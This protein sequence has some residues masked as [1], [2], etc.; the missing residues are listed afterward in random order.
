MKLALPY[1]VLLMLS[2][3]ACSAGTTKK[4][5]VAKD[6]VIQCVKADAAP[7]ITLLVEFAAEALG[8]ALHLGGID[9]DAIVDK[10]VAH[11]KVVG[12]CAGLRFLA[13]LRGAQPASSMRA[14]VAT[15]NPIDEAEAKLRARLGAAWDLG[16]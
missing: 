11:G 7:I 12:G 9:Y 3:T 5:D 2:L 6:G 15:P 4:L 1:V 14:L 16:G 8:S 13:A 10:A